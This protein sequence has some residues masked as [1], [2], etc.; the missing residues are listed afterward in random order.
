MVPPAAL[1]HHPAA[2]LD[3]RPH[4]HAPAEHEVD[5]EV[6][7]LPRG[8]SPGIGP[9]VEAWPEEV[10]SC[11]LTQP[12]GASPLPMAPGQ[13]ALKANVHDGHLAQHLADDLCGKGALPSTVGPSDD[14]YATRGGQAPYRAGVLRRPGR[15]PAHHGWRTHH[16]RA[17]RC[18]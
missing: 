12:A 17:R 11:T 1:E 15:E 9:R 8:R 10:G 4:S 7:R 14:E 6:E 18:W 2:A 5:E 3:E 13:E 16:R